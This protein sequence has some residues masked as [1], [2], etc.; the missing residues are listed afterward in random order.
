MPNINW[1]TIEA[2][3]DGDF[4]RLPAGAYVCAITGAE[5]YPAKQYVVI[6]LDIMDG[7]HAEEFKNSQYPPKIYLSYKDNALPMTKGRLETI[8]AD[9]PGF[10]AMAAFNGNPRLLVSRKAGVLF[11]DEEYV[12]RTGD[13]RTSAKPYRIVSV[14]DVRAGKLKTPKPK[15]LT[16]EEVAQK[17]GHREQAAAQVGASS[18]TQ[19]DEEDIPF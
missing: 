8:Q 9:N 17:G 15:L 7:P 5:D 2:K 1:G 18:T 13:V 4:E 11:R 10:D 14:A 6:T 19:V 16:D 12:S 3:Q